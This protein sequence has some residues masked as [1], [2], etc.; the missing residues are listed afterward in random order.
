MPV[1]ANGRSGAG[2]PGKGHERKKD[3][4]GSLAVGSLHKILGAALGGSSC[5]YHR[6]RPIRPCWGDWFMTRTFSRQELYDLVWSEPKSSLASRL[7]ISDVGL[8]KAC[9]RADIPV[10]GLGYW[11]KLQH[12]KKVRRL[13]L[14]PAALGIR[15]AVTIMLTPTL[16]PDVEAQIQQESSPDHRITVPE[17][18]TDHH[19]LVRAWLDAQRHQLKEAI[20]KGQQLWPTS[21]A[22]W[23]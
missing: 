2:P 12:G 20:R 21:P 22:S 10:P 19:P 18:P 8:A 5:N 11:A 13:P 16:P 23:Q 7:G 4:H 14:P 9:R 1:D 15:D 3:Q 6:D 17:T